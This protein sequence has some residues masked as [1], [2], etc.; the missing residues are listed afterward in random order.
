MKLGLS[1][2]LPHCWLAFMVP[3]GA[4][5]DAWGERASTGSLSCEFYKPTIPSCQTRCAYWSNNGVIIIGV[6][7]CSLSSYEAC[8]WQGT[9]SDKVN[10]IKNKQTKP[11]CMVDEIFMPGGELTSVYYPSFVYHNIKLPPKYLCLY[12]YIS[13]NRS[14][15]QRC[16][17]LKWVVVSTDMLSCSS[18][19]E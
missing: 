9:L 15:N 10:A 1:R 3:K 6:S 14:L 17:P 19:W 13:A 5:Q 11:K 8:P 7:K 16:F 2:K 4:M 12:P 18:C